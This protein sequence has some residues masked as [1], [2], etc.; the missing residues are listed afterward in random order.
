VSRPSGTPAN[1]SATL[2]GAAAT[3]R[4]C[5]GV[6]GGQF[7]EQGR[8]GLLVAGYDFSLLSTRASDNSPVCHRIGSTWLRTERS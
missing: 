1:V 8:V 3:S 7:I 5:G 6:Q 4:R 2:S